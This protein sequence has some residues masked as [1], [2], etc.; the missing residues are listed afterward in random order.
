VLVGWR[1]MVEPMDVVECFRT[2]KEFACNRHR[3]MVQVSAEGRCPHRCC[4]TI[5]CTN[6]SP[7][8]R[9]IS[10]YFTAKIT[11]SP[12]MGMTKVLISIPVDCMGIPRLALTLPWRRSALPDSLLTKAPPPVTRSLRGPIVN[13]VEESDPF[14]APTSQTIH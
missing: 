13:R 3:C 5:S 12:M 7:L 2:A 8:M 14:L 4:V 10:T 9:K 1:L 11:P 6:Q